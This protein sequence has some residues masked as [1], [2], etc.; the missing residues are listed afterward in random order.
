M[1]PEDGVGSHHAGAR[2][3]TVEV[4]HVAAEHAGR[5]AVGRSETLEVAIAPVGGGVLF[6]AVGTLDGAKAL[7]QSLSPHPRP[8][9]RALEGLRQHLF[10][11]A[12]EEEVEEEEQV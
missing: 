12:D 5:R 7:Q 1:F 9:L 4:A 6:G 8:V 10:G 3:E 11:L 2:R